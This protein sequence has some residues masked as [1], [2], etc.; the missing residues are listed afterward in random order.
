MAIQVTIGDLHD[1]VDLAGPC[2]LMVSL[3]HPSHRKCI[4]F[5]AHHAD[6]LLQNL[7]CV[8]WSYEIPV[9]KFEAIWSVIV[10]LVE[11]RSPQQG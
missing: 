2:P 10:G 5:A 11:P 9:S 4:G 8:A 7:Y 1:N 6:F 3:Q